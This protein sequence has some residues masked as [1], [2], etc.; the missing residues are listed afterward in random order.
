MPVTGCHRST[1]CVVLMQCR[2][3]GSC[4][5]S[6]LSGKPDISGVGAFLVELHNPV[7]VLYC[8]LSLSPPLQKTLVIFAQ[9]RDCCWFYVCL[10]TSSEM[11]RIPAVSFQISFWFF[12]VVVV[13]FL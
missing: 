3:A 10:K 1:R 9:G 13:L 4:S 6:H 11:L 2:L 7:F 8:F 12:V 5:S